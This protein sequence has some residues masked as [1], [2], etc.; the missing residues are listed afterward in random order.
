MG[1]PP[2]DPPLLNS[3][4]PWCT[5]LTDLQALYN[6]PHTGAIT[7]RTSLI[8]GFAHDP[9]IHQHSFF[10]PRSHTCTTKGTPDYHIP[11]PEN[12]S[13]N[14]LGYSPL[15]LSAYLDFITS[16][17]PPP[18]SPSCPKPIIISITGTPTQILDAYTIIAKHA[19]TLPPT[20]P[21][22]V[23]INLSCPNIPSKPPPAYSGPE[24]L[25][26]LT[27]LQNHPDFT[28]PNRKVKVGIKTPPYTYHDQFATLVSALRSAAE[29]LP[30]NVLP[31]DFVT[32]TNTLGSCLLLDGEG[33]PVLSGANGAGIGGMAGA[34]LHPLSLGNVRSVRSLLDAEERLRDIDVIGVGGVEDRSGFERMRTA[35]AKVV[36][37]GTALG[38]EGVGIF[39]KIRE[40]Q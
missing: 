32:A 36:G 23:E 19:T 20:K 31:V 8:N 5:T 25:T 21:L 12:S 16:L 40:G 29:S 14:T 22:L 33:K 37:V 27:A 35:G 3:A 17:N 9:S 2:I 30:A 18:T 7:T 10:D 38:R 1:L 26:Y 4:N 24:L 39:A 15:S 11:T 13:L 34:A 6:S 28:S